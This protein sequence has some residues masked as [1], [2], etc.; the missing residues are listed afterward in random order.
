VLS[1]VAV[2]IVVFVAGCSKDDLTIVRNG[3]LG[4]NKAIAIGQALDGYNYF[5]KRE[6]QAIKTP[7]G[8]R[9][10]IFKA[11]M[12]PKFIKEINE[13]CGKQNPQGKKI[14]SQK[15]SIQ[16]TINKDNTVHIS[17]TQTLSIFTDKTN[18]TGSLNEELLKAVFENKLAAVCM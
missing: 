6:W 18:K 5:E 4:F 15:W 7:K 11:D 8:G 1:A 12:N 9:L 16:F 13:A 10:V 2:L 3:H 14:D 17:G